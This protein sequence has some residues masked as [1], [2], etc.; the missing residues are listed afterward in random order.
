MLLALDQVLQVAFLVARL[1]QLPFKGTQFLDVPL[2]GCG[3]VSLQGGALLLKADACLQ[4]NMWVAATLGVVV[5]ACSGSNQTRWLLLSVKVRVV[6]IGGGVLKSA[7]RG[8]R[9]LD[10]IAST[11]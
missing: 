5:S 10:V 4:V 11:L 9:G 2:L 3:N 1:L 6:I 8:G 7:R